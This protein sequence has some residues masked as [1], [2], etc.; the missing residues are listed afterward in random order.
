M[1][2]VGEKIEMLLDLFFCCRTYSDSS[3]HQ[4][5]NPTG[6]THDNQQTLHYDTN[7]TKYSPPAPSYA[8]HHFPSMNAQYPSTYS[9]DVNNNNYPNDQTHLFHA[10]IV[11]QNSIS[12]SPQRYI[13]GNNNSNVL[14]LPPNPYSR[15]GGS[16][17]DLRLESVYNPPDQTMIFSTLSSPSPTASSQCFRSPSPHENGDDDLFSLV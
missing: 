8:S 4:S 15:N 13:G 2:K 7:E 16:L 9:Y 3:L 11:Q 17:P 5:M 1:A 10:P 6:H 14:M 12:Y